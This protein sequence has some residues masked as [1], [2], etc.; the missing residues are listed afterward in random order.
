[1]VSVAAV[2][3]GAGR[4]AGRAAVVAAGEEL[5]GGQVGGVQVVQDGADL[6]GVGV[7]MVFGAVARETDGPGAAT[8][9]GELTAEGGQ[10]ACRGQVAEF[11]QRRRDGGGDDGTSP[12]RRL[13]VRSWAPGR[14]M[15]GGIGAAPGFSAEWVIRWVSRC[16]R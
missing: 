5:A 10:D 3:L 12:L 7:E 2:G 13:V 15:L 6:A 11:G 8:E 1:M 9:P 14:R 16:R 4:A